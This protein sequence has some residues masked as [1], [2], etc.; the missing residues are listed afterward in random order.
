MKK[1]EYSIAAGTAPSESSCQ[2]IQAKP[3]FGDKCIGCPVMKEWNISRADTG[4]WRKMHDQSIK[5]EAILK[6]ENKDLKAK[7]KLREKQLFGKRS[8]KNKSDCESHPGKPI[9]PNRNRG[10]QR[11]KPGNGRKK[12]NNLP[13]V[14]ETHDLPESEKKCACCGLPLKP[15]PDADPSDVIEVEVKAHVRRIVRKQYK[16]SCNCTSQPLIVTADPPPKLVPKGAYGNSVWIE[17]LLNKFQFHQPTARL[18]SRF[19]LLGLDISQGTITDGLKRLSPLFEPVYDQIVNNNRE[20]D[21]W[22]ADETRWFVFAHIEGKSGYNWWLWVFKS[23]ESVVFILDKSRSADVP[24]HHFENIEHPAILS[25]DRYSAYKCVIKEK[26]GILIVAWCWAH[27]RRD[28][29][30]LAKTRPEL[31][32]WAMKWV[33]DI[34]QLYYLNGLR[35]ENMEDP[36]SF[37][38]HDDELKQSLERMKDSCDNQLAEEAL[39]PN[40]RKVLESL[41]NHWGGLTVFADYPAIPMDNNAAERAF[42]GPVTGRKNYYGAGAV[43]SGI[44]TAMMFSIFQT[45]QLWNINPKTWLEEFFRACA[46]NG[47]KPLDDVSSFMPWNMDQQTLKA[48]AE[49]SPDIHDTS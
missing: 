29:L 39:D 44:L 10:H 35:L 25:C 9:G 49:S 26:G 33:Y 16:R 28:F 1:V 6:Q 30:D 17:V 45:L 13:E 5:R 46:E 37:S 38:Q 21:H 32:P 14:P 22:H 41:D 27:V 3:L 47:G 34:G 2:K 7:L 40:C 11:G 4:Y 42:R 24:R 43:W 20:A 23:E 18:L 8:E 19:D 36:E 48:Y 15:F 31:D 12:R